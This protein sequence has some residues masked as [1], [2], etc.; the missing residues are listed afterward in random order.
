MMP[1]TE[2]SSNENTP[3]QIAMAG[4]QQPNVLIGSPSDSTTNS[5]GGIDQ[6]FYNK[7]MLLRH[8]YWLYCHGH[9]A[10]YYSQCRP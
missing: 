2:S 10:H 8:W 4:N 1:V 9:V 5:I 6:V 7:Q 3:V